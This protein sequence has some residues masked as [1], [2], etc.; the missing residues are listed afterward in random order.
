ME[1]ATNDHTI[2][3]KARSAT[4]SA[5]VLV[6][7]GKQQV[8]DLG[9]RTVEQI[10]QATTRLGDGVAQVGTAIKSTGRSTGASIQEVGQYLQQK[11][12]ASM[13]DDLMQVVRRHPGA[14][15]ALGMG[16]GALLTRAFGASRR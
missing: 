6:E 11:D 12:P 7:R 3:D 5:T 14:T 10:D 4:E 1:Q 8:A 9:D 15:L 13:K 16:L 2:H